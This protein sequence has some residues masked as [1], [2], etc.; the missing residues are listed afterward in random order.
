MGKPSVLH[1]VPSFGLG[2]MEKVICSIMRQTTEKYQHTLLALNGV[3]DALQWLPVRITSIPFQKSVHN[4]VFLKELY[5]ALQNT[6]TDFLMTYNWGATDAIWLGR[7]AG[8]KK[9]VHS[10]HGFN[11]DE[12]QFTSK[13]RDIIRFFLYHIASKIVVVSQ[14]LKTMMQTKYYLSNSKLAFIPNGLNLHH[15]YINEENR[16]KFRKD[17]KLNT[18]DF[19]LG[20]LGRL[21]PVKNLDL[22]L[23]IFEFCLQKDSDFKFLFIGDGPERT[24]LEQRCYQKNIQNYVIFVGKK[25]NI[26]PYLSCVDMLLL[27]SFREQ[28]PM[29]ILESMAMGIPVLATKVGDIPFMIENEKDG[30]LRNLHDSLEEFAQPI[31]SMKNHPAHARII[32]QMAKRKVETYQ[33][34]HMIQRY[35]D[36]LEKC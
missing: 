27:T 5:H 16:G 7:L 9:I 20:F 4:F 3:E 24:R 19:V 34:S 10:E 28:M 21:D 15:Y 18:T 6:Q 2:G 1:V 11:I 32:G 26:V 13:K 17:M 8:I 35:I 14:S 30:F 23:E 25:D 12:A 29:S 36:V 33:E 22:M 31:F